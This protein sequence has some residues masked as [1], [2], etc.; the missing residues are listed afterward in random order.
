MRPEDIIRTWKHRGTHSA[1]APVNSVPDNPA[2]RLVLEDELE[3][4]NGAETAY[5]FTLGCC[6]GFTNVPST[7]TCTWGLCPTNW[8]YTCQR[9]CW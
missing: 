8:D 2:G 1:A 4:V 9:G 5:G 7:C 3:M 6:S